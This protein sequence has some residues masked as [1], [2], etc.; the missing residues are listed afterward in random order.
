MDMAEGI[1][2]FLFGLGAIMIIFV[3]A[4]A[5][6]YY[7][8]GWKLLKKAGKGGWEILI[9]FYSTYV[10]VEIAGLNW[11]Y[12]LIAISGSILSLIGLEGL[13]LITNLASIF[14]NF[15]IFYNIAKKM[16]QNEVLYGVLGALVSPITLM[17]LGFSKNIAY[18]NTIEVSPN[19]PIG[20]SNTNNTQNNNIN[21]KYCPKCGQKLLNNANFC[22]NCGNKIEN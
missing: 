19:G 4:I 9:P 8:A 20:T 21:S 14:V 7:I 10:L 6:P 17:I 5:I 22:E 12:F 2:F 11:W 15:L 3:I 13:S 16:K 1:I 18:D